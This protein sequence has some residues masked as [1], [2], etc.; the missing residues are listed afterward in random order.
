MKKIL[1]F[2]FIISATFATAG[3]MPVTDVKIS[4]DPPTEKERMLVNSS[5]SPTETKTYDKMVY[6]CTLRQVL[7]L[8][9]RDG[10]V[11]KKI[12]EPVK[13]TYTRE[14][15]RMTKELD[16]HIHF[17]VPVGLKELREKYGRLTFKF[18]YPVTVSHVKIEAYAK[19]EKVW[20]IERDMKK[21]ERK[22][23]TKRAGMMR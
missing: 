9:A 5:F 20:Q 22:K 18:D 3:D 1:I 21:P 13:F 11:R 8:P 2:A 12:Y 6:T 19:G 17:P 23:K 4:L 10:G 16:K 15:V 14:N 7:K